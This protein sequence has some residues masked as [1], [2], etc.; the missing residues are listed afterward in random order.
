M[1]LSQRAQ[2]PAFISFRSG[3]VL[4]LQ[5]RPS[6]LHLWCR[7]WNR[8]Q[9]EL[10]QAGFMVSERR[11]VSRGPSGL[12]MG[13]NVAN[14]GR[15]RRPLSKA[16]ISLRR[17][18]YL[19]LT[20]REIRL[21]LCVPTKE[22]KNSEKPHLSYQNNNLIFLHFWTF[23]FFK[24]V[25]FDKYDTKTTAYD[26]NGWSEIGD[27][28]EFLMSLCSFQVIHIQK[29]RKTSLVNFYFYFFCFVVAPL[30]HHETWVK[31]SHLQ[32]FSDI[33]FLLENVM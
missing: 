6:L 5:Q 4:R 9:R 19:I 28:I 31:K 24:T 11:A 33:D 20:W 3:G 10:C 12:W 29:W 14:H 21:R 23:F 27:W 30:K 25:N 18:R 1:Q 7:R 15:H 17:M 26:W 32:S 13:V 22:S 8:T 2:T 16:Y